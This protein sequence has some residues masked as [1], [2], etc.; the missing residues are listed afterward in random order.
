MG[1]HEPREG[2]NRR[3]RYKTSGR[4]F[5]TSLWPDRAGRERVLLRCVLGGT[6][7]PGV[8][9]LSDD[10]M[11][12]VARADVRT[13]LG[14]EAEPEHANVVRWP[15]AIAQYELGH[16]GRVGRAEE[17]A[18]PL[19]IVLA[20]SSYRGVS[21]NDCIANARRAAREAAA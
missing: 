5:E 2:D 17:L 10:E 3:Q 20:G 15:V 14:V 18:R 6:R 16:L 11:I 12:G 19:G 4:H 7:D 8:L 13:A 21:V 1:G 9:D